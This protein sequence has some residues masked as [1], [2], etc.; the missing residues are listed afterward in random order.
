MRPYVILWNRD[1]NVRGGLERDALATT[2][3]GEVLAPLGAALAKLG[4]VEVVETG[5][6]DPEGLARSLKA[7][8]PRV[9][10][11]LAEAA[12]GAA[13]LEPCVAGVLELLGIPYTGNTPETL[14]LCLD[15]P[16]TKLLLRGA[17][18]PVPPGVVVRDAA[19]DPIVGLE[20]PVIVKPAAMDASH[21]IEPSNVVW[22]ERAARAKAAELIA[23][24]PP[25]ALVERFIDGRDMLVGLIQVGVGAP[26]T[27]LPLG[28]ID[29]QLPPG[30]PRVCGFESKWV[31]SSEAFRRTPGIYPAVVSAA[32]EGRV[33]EAA[34]AAFQAVGGRD[35]ARV[36]IRI[37]ADER[38]FVLEVNPNPCLS[39]YTGLGRAARVAGWTY[40]D[41]IHRI[42]RNAEERGPLAPLPRRG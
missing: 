21:G 28:E 6:G 11:N 34:A 14:A 4:P 38:L 24:F 35:Y 16:R 13:E 15:K 30:V 27:V 2:S 9:V 17:G 10:F 32:L 39:P 40:D 42:V 33:R 37:D 29:F 12:R 3:T 26:P 20:Y 18:V 22:D 36:D 23:R 5:D 41:L 25:A 1:A 7:R 8:D 19:H 31:T